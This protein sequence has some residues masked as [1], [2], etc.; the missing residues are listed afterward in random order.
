M[1]EQLPTYGSSISSP[2]GPELKNYSLKVQ[3]DSSKIILN[4]MNIAELLALRGEI[5]ALLPSTN[6]KDFNAQEEVMLQYQRIKALQ[7]EVS[8]DNNTPTNQK[9]QVANTL[10]KLLNDI[11]G[12]RNELYNTEQARLMEAALAKALRGQ[13][14]E[15]Q[16]AFFAVYQKTAEEMANAGPIAIS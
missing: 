2:N 7:L 4:A 13:P 16:A 3:M 10:A 1:S 6:L 11:V 12:M 14:E 9:A 15:F 5:D 8:Q